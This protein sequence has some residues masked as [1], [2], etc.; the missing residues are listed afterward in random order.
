[1]PPELL[2]MA[3]QKCVLQFLNCPAWP[4]EQCCTLSLLPLLHFKQNNAFQI[5]VHVP[6]PSSSIIFILT[7]FDAIIFYATNFQSLQYFRDENVRRGW[8]NLLFSSLKKL[9]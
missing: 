6:L 8:F 4:T 7:K 2:E 1:M 3:H 5:E 9:N